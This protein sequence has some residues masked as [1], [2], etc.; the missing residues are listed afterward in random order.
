[1]PT[2]ATDRPE[3]D[4]PEKDRYTYEDY[5]Q[6]PEGAPYELI[7][8]HLVVSPS[9]TVEHQRL[10]RKLSRVLDDYRRSAE[11]SGEVLFAPMDVHLSDETVVQPDVLYVSPDRADRIGAQDIQGAPDLVMEVVSPSTSHRDV[12]DKKRLYEQH[13]VREYWIVDPDTTTVEVHVLT[14]EELALHQRCVEEGTA[15]SALLDD[16]T[17][18]LSDL[19]REH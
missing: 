15:A 17:V 7:H 3:V 6:L 4:L 12:F 18:D 19:F 11:T 13:G 1:M 14:D 5:Q 2:P 16:F 10:V 8:G 9:P